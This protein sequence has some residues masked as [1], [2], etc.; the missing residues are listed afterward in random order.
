VVALLAAQLALTWVHGS[1]LHRQHQEIQGLREDLQGLAESIDQQG[2]SGAAEGEGGLVPSRTRHRRALRGVRVV[3]ISMQD[4]APEQATKDLDESKKSAE[5][6]IK[7]AREVQQKLSIEENARK[8]EEKAKIERAQNAWQK[9]I[10][11]GL[12]AGLLA[13]VLRSWMRRRG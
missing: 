3:H 4:D 8:A 12:G 1:L 6:A 5:K 9:W 11:I 2:A 13:F 10:W 7:D